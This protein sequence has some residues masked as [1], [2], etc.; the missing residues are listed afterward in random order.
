MLAKTADPR[1]RGLPYSATC[2]DAVDVCQETFGLVEAL[3]IFWL[4]CHHEDSRASGM[5]CQVVDQ[6]AEVSWG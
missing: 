5:S 4:Q 3:G 2:G 1:M 6:S